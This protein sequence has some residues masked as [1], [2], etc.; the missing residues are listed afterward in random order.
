MKMNDHHFRY[1]EV[2]P[3]FQLIKI[4]IEN[5]ILQNYFAHLYEM[6]FLYKK[7]FQKKYMLGEN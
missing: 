6:H 1:M 7:K 2:N 5:K 4:H 3:R